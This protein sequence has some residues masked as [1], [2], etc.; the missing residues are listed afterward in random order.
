[1]LFVKRL[2][3]VIVRQNGATVV[4]FGLIAPV[5]MLFIMGVV[6]LGLLLT[7]QTI[8]D[9]AA[10]AASR[11]GKTGYSTA[12]STQQSL[13]LAAVRKAA[14]G[15]LD[16]SRLSMTSKAYSDYGNVGQPEPFTDKNNNGV[17]NSGESY[18]D[19]NGNGSW[20]KDQ[21]TSGNG[22]SGQI[23]VYTVTYDWRLFTPMLSKLIGTNGVVALSSRIVVK[24]EPF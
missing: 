21:G 5:L 1:M 13:I 10:F 22:A 9:N 6:E 4:E 11:V 24:N 3:S 14:S 15:Y 8:L 23:V 17:W 19:V 2:H 12:T 18:T 16:P 7:A 20:D